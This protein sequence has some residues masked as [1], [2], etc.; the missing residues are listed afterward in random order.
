MLATINIRIDTNKFKYDS[1]SPLKN[2][3]KF[4]IYYRDY[5]FASP[6]DLFVPHSVV[7]PVF[8][9]FTPR[10]PLLAIYVNLC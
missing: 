2:T 10:F 6:L 7:Y 1:T 3:G 8:Y 9:P 5:S 4:D